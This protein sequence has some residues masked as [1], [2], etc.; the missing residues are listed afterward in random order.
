M[1]D[2]SEL[3]RLRAENAILTQQINEIRASSPQLTLTESTRRIGGIELENLV[4]TTY[5]RW[6]KSASFS[7]LMRRTA[8]AL[9]EYPGYYTWIFSLVALDPDDTPKI[10]SIYY[11]V[12][13]G[14]LQDL[15]NSFETIP[16]STPLNRKWQGCMLIATTTD[17]FT[18]GN[19]WTVR[20]SATSPFTQPAS[21]TVSVVENINDEIMMN[22][23]PNAVSFKLI[24][25]SS[26]VYHIMTTDEFFYQTVY[27]TPPDLE[28][29]EPIQSQPVHYGTAA[30]T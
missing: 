22:L 20:A 14:S 5:W 7:D 15:V 27:I 11:N 25:D 19:S 26:T 28:S 3:T 1:L 6:S 30:V 8:T 18:T 4:T 17:R 9:G 16:W 10:N 13:V 24:T 12:Y 29:E 2:D 23:T 21:E